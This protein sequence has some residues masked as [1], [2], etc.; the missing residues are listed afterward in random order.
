MC[1]RVILNKIIQELDMFHWRVK[2]A[3]SLKKWKTKK[4]RS[5]DLQFITKQ[6]F[7]KVRKYNREKREQ[8]VEY[9]LFMNMLHTIL[10]VN[11]ELTSF[12][13]NH[14]SSSVHPKNIKAPHP[15][16]TPCIGQIF[17]IAFSKWILTKIFHSFKL[18]I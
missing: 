2:L 13:D 1:L 14:C 5:Y 16:L 3:G 17:W 4:K 8:E 6:V 9:F 12:S 10:E 18:N 11:K 15:E 7:K